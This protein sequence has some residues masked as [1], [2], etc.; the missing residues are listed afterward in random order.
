MNTQTKEQSFNSKEL[1]KILPSY[2]LDEIDEQ[3]N[4]QNNLFENNLYDSSLVKEN[5]NVRKI[6]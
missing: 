6:I 2:L 1:N 4:H 5:K 3:Q